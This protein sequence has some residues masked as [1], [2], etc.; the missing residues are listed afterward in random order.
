MAYSTNRLFDKRKAAVQKKVVEAPV[1]RKVAGGGEGVEFRP[2]DVNIKSNID[3]GSCSSESSVLKCLLNA[4]GSIKLDSAEVRSSLKPYRDGSRGNAKQVDVTDTRA[5]LAIKPDMSRL[6]AEIHNI[7][8]TYNEDPIKG[9]SAEEA[10]ESAEW[11][12]TSVS[13]DLQDFD[14]T[15]MEFDLEVELA[16]NF[17]SPQGGSSLEITSEDAIACSAE[18]TPSNIAMAHYNGLLDDDY[19]VQGHSASKRVVKKASPSRATLIKNLS[20]YEK[21]QV[22][23]KIVDQEKRLEEAWDAKPY[24]EDTLGTVE[25]WLSHAESC[26]KDSYPSSVKGGDT[27]DLNEVLEVLEE[28]TEIL[29][30]ILGSQDSFYNP[31]QLSLASRKAKKAVAITS[32]PLVKKLEGL[33]SKASDQDQNDASPA[34]GVIQQLADYRLN[35]GKMNYKKLVEVLKD[36]E[37]DIDGAMANIK[38]ISDKELRKQVRSLLDESIKEYKAFLRTKKMASVK[39]AGWLEDIG[40]GYNVDEEE[41]YSASA[42]DLYGDVSLMAEALQAVGAGEA[43]GRIADS[44]F[45]RRTPDDVDLWGEAVVE[46]QRRK[47]PKH[48][49]EAA[50]SYLEYV[51]DWYNESHE[52]N[53]SDYEHTASTD[54]DKAPDFIKL[55]K[56]IKELISTF[57]RDLNKAQDNFGKDS[58]SNGTWSTERGASRWT[59]TYSGDMFP[60][61]FA[62]LKNNNEA[63]TVTSLEKHINLNASRGQGSCF[64]DWTVGGDIKI[65][66]EP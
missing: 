44:L 55:D 65:V 62:I 57:F 53:S 51:Q 12:V 36:L 5:G 39:R 21:Q 6:A 56:E 19:D 52:L 38:D 3:L 7:F 60:E 27:T 4:D 42:G 54:F 63:P 50:E 17:F 1:K 11:Y 15:S 34:E 46:L 24:A 23:N 30:N 45:N 22:L 16:I 59:K 10:V 41:W 18:Y 43:S 37:W 28:A 8:E 58:G 25:G 48:V 31:K 13:N 2:Q 26:L 29:D 9:Y 61:F 35:S 49:I 66:I 33:L 40:P 14:S 20:L 32:D 47:A 64:I